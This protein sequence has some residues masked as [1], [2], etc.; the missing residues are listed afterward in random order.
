[1]PKVKLSLPT[2]QYLL[3]FVIALAIISFVFKML[4]ARY[5]Q[6]FRW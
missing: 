1:M 4:P 3:S 2:L 5:T 6:Y